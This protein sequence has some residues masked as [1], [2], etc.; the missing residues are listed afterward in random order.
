[1]GKPASIK[2]AAG[3][4][5]LW[6]SFIEAGS[7]KVNHSKLLGVPKV[8]EPSVPEPRNYC[9]VMSLGFEDPNIILIGF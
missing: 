8:L 4:P 3:G 1:M 2:E 6:E 5:P 9:V 7:P